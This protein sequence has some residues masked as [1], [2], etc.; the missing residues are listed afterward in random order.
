MTA[1]LSGSEIRED[2]PTPEPDTGPGC[3]V[4]RIDAAFWHDR[5]PVTGGVPASSWRAWPPR[6]WRS[7]PTS[8]SARGPGRRE[9]SLAGEPT[10][11]VPD[12]A[13]APAP[14]GRRSRRSASSAVA[15]AGAG[16]RRPPRLRRSWIGSRIGAAEKALDAATG[17]R[18]RADGGAAD[19]AR[20]DGRGGQPGRDRRPPRPQAGL[21]GPRSFATGSRRR[22]RGEAS[23]AASATSWP[24][25]WRP[26]AAPR[27]PSRSRS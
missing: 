9:P 22:S 12:P 14:R 8:S 26:F 27:G 6:S 2:D 18:V 13:R 19:A 10:G 3:R 25:R 15:A 5:R 16:R 20:R 21:P 24:R 1:R 4:L 17:D 23:S 7:R 11:V